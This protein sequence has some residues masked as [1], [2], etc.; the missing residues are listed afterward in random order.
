MDRHA[1]GSRC[2]R[3]GYVVQTSR[4]AADKELFYCNGVGA[5]AF[6]TGRKEMLRLE[7][8][9]DERSFITRTLEVMVM[10][11]LQ[12]LESWATIRVIHLAGRR[13]IICIESVTP[14]QMFL[15]KPPVRH[16]ATDDSP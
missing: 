7:S 1:S 14:S 9:W 16:A 4:N 5:G 11:R 8:I 6:Y 12:S 13:P 15:V 2:Y 3:F 10:P